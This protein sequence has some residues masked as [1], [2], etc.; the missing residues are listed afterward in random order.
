MLKNYLE[1][2]LNKEVKKTGD[3]QNYARYV[4]LNLT[5]RVFRRSSWH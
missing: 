1:K 3:V 5:V 2:E 4:N